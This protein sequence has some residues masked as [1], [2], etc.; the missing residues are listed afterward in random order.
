MVK[1]R[2]MFQAASR[3]AAMAIG[4]RSIMKRTPILILIRDCDVVV[5]GGMGRGM[6]SALYQA[7]IEVA[8]SSVANARNAAEMLIADILP[9]SSGSGCCHSEGETA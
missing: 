9:A 6:L 8:M 4:W 3:A 5:A 2:A 1:D 7:G